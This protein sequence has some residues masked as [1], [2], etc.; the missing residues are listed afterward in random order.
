[1]ATRSIVDLLLKSIGNDFNKLSIGYM[2]ILGYV[3]LNLGKLNSVEQ[4]L[5]LSLIGVVSVGMGIISAY[6]FC[7]LGGKPERLNYLTNI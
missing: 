4:R 1:M 6:G 3:C 2:L 5:F 7:Q